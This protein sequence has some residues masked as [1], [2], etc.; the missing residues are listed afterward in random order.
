MH[1]EMI[2]VAGEGTDSR[3]Y[4]CGLIAM[5]YTSS[6]GKS[7]LRSKDKDRIYLLQG[8]TESLHFVKDIDGY[9]AS[10]KYNASSGGKGLLAL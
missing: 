2:T 3:L 4:I 7:F 1:M 8:K 5:D 9:Y 6:T 10:H